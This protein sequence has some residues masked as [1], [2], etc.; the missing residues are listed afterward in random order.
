MKKN[1]VSDSAHKEYSF[2]EHWSAPTSQFKISR[3]SVN[4]LS[5]SALCKNPARWRSS[6][7]TVTVVG[8]T[9]R[10]LISGIYD[11]ISNNVIATLSDPR[12]P[13]AA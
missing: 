13:D 7:V 3:M 8:T 11:G 9:G 1:L 2:F 6:D 12:R 5:L 4:H 10:G